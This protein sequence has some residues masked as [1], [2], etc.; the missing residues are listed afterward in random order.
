MVT[1]TG[2]AASP[3]SWVATRRRIRSAKLRDSAAVGS[4]ILAVRWL[5]RRDLAVVST[6]EARELRIY[7]IADTGHELL[8]FD[9]SRISRPATGAQRH[10][11]ALRIDTRGGGV[12]LLQLGARLDQPRLPDAR[13]ARLTQ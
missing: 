5:P 2:L 9:R 12:V 4:G 11:R 6:K 1:R 3:K 7:R 10:E 8:G 13:A